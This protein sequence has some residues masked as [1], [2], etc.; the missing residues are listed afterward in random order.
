VS[1]TLLNR[2]LA[3]CRRVFLLLSLAA[4]LFIAWV[5]W[6][7]PGLDTIRPNIERYLQHDLN[8]KEL[9][10]GNL[11]WYW[12]GFLW[13]Q[14]DEL[15]FTNLDESLAFHHGRV[16]VRLPLLA[17]LSGNVAPDRIRLSGGEIDVAFAASGAPA[18]VGQLILDHVTINWGYGDLHGSIADLTLTLDGAKRSLKAAAPSLKLAGSLD[19]DGLLRELDLQCKDTGW[20]PESLRARLQGSALT[21]MHLKRSDQHSWQADFTLSSKAPVTIAP[22]ARHSFAFNSLEGELNITLDNTETMQAERIDI[23]RLAWSLGENSITA[24]GS[25][26]QGQLSLQ[27]ASGNLEMP[28]V[29]GWLHDLGDEQWRHWLTLMHTGH[30][31]RATGELKL[32]WALPLQQWPSDQAWQAMSY[33]LLADV[34]DADIALGISDDYLLQTRGQVDLNQDGLLA[35]IAGTELPRGLGSSSG[36]LRIPWD[37]LEL[38]IS[39]RAEADM[40]GLLKWLEPGIG[41]DWQWHAARAKGTFKLLWDPSET[42]PKQASAVLEPLDTWHVSMF[43]QD[44]NLLA[45]SILWNKETGLTLNKMQIRADHMNAILSLAASPAS[46]AGPKPAAGTNKQWQL[47]SLDAHIQGKLSSLATR[48]QIPVS[49]VDGSIS[50]T[51]HYDG[52]WSGIL[53]MQQAGWQH[54]LGSSKNIG[55]PF[56]LH[57]QGELKTVDGVPTVELSEL[58][59]R[60]NVLKLYGGSMSINRERIKARLKDMHTPSF[61]GSL[62]I[63]VPFDDKPWQADVRARYL[64]RNALPESLDHP[65]QLIDKRWILHANIDRFDWD[66]ASMSGVRLNLSSQSDSVGEFEAAQIHTS[67]LD[68]MDVGARFTLP[69]QGRVELRKLAASVEKQHLLMSATLTPEE[70]GGMRWSGFTE[71]E[72]DFGHLMKLGALSERFLGGRGHILFSGQGLIL[73]DQPWWQGLDGRLRLRV[74]NGRILEGGSLTTLL[75]AIN[76]SK[77]PALLFGKRDDLSGPGIKYERLQMEAIIQNQDIHI[78][79][80]AMRSTAFDLVGHGKLDIDQATIDLYLIAR[81]LQNIDALLARVPLLRDIVGGAA[82][83]FMRKVYHMYG[84]FT[85]AKVASVEPEQAGLASAGL[86]ERMLALPNE[87]FGSEENA[88]TP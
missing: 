6:Q 83:S 74:D 7:T 2:A 14:A 33:H 27:A 75:A 12:S 39:G 85:D 26:Q 60:G 69:G 22:D 9:Q 50:S 23:K 65:Q 71:L 67:Q 70:G 44:L 77:L 47:Q 8:L 53:D 34:E 54:L 46:V 18:P 78:R 73:R 49:D 13:I 25:W 40:A 86:I 20:L 76:L 61:S 51:L 4:T 72:G 21:G 43:G 57:Y 55:E 62:A 68:I 66:E 32:A 38:D 19:Q 56:S 81:P 84:P 87:W 31:S 82:H 35:T 59:S 15:N 41:A 24:H 28:L 29:W 79:N 36:E 10:L 42:E 52:H 80:V 88:A 3:S 1:G 58:Q 16:A 5:Y 37:T 63:N 17:M 30:A 11:S 45:G 64:N 48:Y